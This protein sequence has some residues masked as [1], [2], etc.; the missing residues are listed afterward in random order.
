MTEI[1]QPAADR[2][3]SCIG[4]MIGGGLAL[5]AVFIGVSLWA[6]QGR[7]PE[8]DVDLHAQ[9]FAAWQ[10]VA[11]T[12]YDIEIQVTGRQPALYAV[13]V[14]DHK[15]TTATR[16]GIPLVQRR[17]MGTWSVPGMFDTIESDLINEAGDRDDRL[18][19][20]SP[21]V[22]VRTRFHPK[23]HYPDAYQRIEWG[24][25]YEV[26]WKVVKF[27]VVDE[28]MGRNDPIDNSAK[29]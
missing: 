11:P 20:D 13:R 27:T 2:R 9:E 8:V 21:R 15:V 26:E 12:S 6:R 10:R 29:E 19:R 18:T 24:S 5:V 4:I 7:L 28:A 17:T 3:L 14:R 25:H 23:W 1:E 22:I 16:N